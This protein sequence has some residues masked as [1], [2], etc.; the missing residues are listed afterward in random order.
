MP[1][2]RLHAAGVIG[3]HAAQEDE[4]A[5]DVEQG[6]NGIAQRAIGRGQDRAGGLRSTKTLAIASM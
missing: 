1:T 5:G 2:K 4:R 3:E 6:S